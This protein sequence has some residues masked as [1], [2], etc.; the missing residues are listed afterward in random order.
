MLAI[1]AS[2]SSASSTELPAT[3]YQNPADFQLF[4]LYTTIWD[5]YLMNNIILRQMDNNSAKNWVKLSQFLDILCVMSGPPFPVK[6]TWGQLKNQHQ[7]PTSPAS[8]Q[9][10]NQWI[11]PKSA[12]QHTPAAPGKPPRYPGTCPQWPTAPRQPPR[13]PGTCFQ[14]PTAS[15]RDPGLYQHP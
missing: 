6:F 14:Q 5:W 15:P 3:G 13:D 8:Q 7:L 1:L 11:Q 9:H 2:S 4:Q 12:N 10:Q